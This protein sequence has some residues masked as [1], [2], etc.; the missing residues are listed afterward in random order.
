V[1]SWPK[2]TLS[3]LY[4]GT[5]L[6]SR[7]QRRIDRRRRQTRTRPLRSDCTFTHATTCSS[8][9]QDSM[10][11][12]PYHPEDIALLADIQLQ[13]DKTDPLACYM[14]RKTDEYPATYRHTTLR[15]LPTNIARTWY[16]RVRSGNGRYRCLAVSVPKFERHHH[17][18]VNLDEA[19]PQ[20]GGSQ[21]AGDWK[22]RNMRYMQSKERTLSYALC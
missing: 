21:V 12:R 16:D 7:L 8:S 2:P 17:W 9:E 14:V 3:A 13:C 6:S 10:H 5:I 19:R 18:L 11:L 1:C 20:L 22:G 4:A 15:F